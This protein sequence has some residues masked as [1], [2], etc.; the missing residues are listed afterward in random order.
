[1]E[2]KVFGK[3]H[4]GWFPSLH[5]RTGLICIWQSC[6]IV[7]F[8]VTLIVP[9]MQVRQFMVLSQKPKMGYTFARTNVNIGELCSLATQ[10]CIASCALLNFT[11]LVKQLY[12]LVMT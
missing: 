1:V 8:N 10:F 3:L 9:F 11:L 4:L 12:Y 6:S 7:L 2:L 5:E